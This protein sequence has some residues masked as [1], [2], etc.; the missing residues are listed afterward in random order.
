M[1]HFLFLAISLV[2]WA[3]TSSCGP[4]YVLRESEEVKDGVWTYADSAV[5]ALEVVDTSKRYAIAIALQHTTGYAFQNL[6]LR[7]HTRFPNGQ[8]LS[9]PISLELAGKAG[10]WLGKCRGK[11]CEIVIPIQENAF[12]NATGTHRFV[13]EQYMRTDSLPGIRSVGFHIYEM[14]ARK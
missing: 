14:S 10:N 7:I 8:R 6:Y 1:K 2:I 9:Q 5:F 12:F 4:R 3:M 13:L 11:G